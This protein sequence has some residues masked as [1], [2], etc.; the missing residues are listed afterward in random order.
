[1]EIAS[2][3]T[4][5]KV[6]YDIAKGISSIKTEVERNEAIAEILRVLISVEHDALVMQNDHS[7]LLREKDDL[8]RE[9]DDLIKKISEFE[10]WNETETQYELKSIAP[11]IFVFSYKETS[12]TTEPAHWLCANCYNDRKKSV[13]QLDHVS[14]TGSHYVCHKCNS[15]ITIHDEEYLR[16]SRSSYVNLDD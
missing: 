1:M 11:G 12:Q 6:A 7:L 15:K 8:L 10:K 13:I 4:S 5:A 2:L 14:A 9:K 16:D 3:F